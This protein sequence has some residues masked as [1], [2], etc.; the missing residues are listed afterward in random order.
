MRQWRPVMLL[1]RWQLSVGV[2]F[3]CIMN[4]AHLVICCSKSL[5]FNGSV[6]TF[7]NCLDLPSQGASIGWTLADD[8]SSTQGYYEL[9]LAFLGTAPSESGWVG[10]G[11]NPSK[12]QMAGSSVWV[13]Y[14]AANG[15]TLLPY[16][17]TGATLGGAPLQCSPVD[18]VVKA[19]A[20]QIS[21]VA[22]SML[23]TLQLNASMPTTLYHV[24]N[25]GP[26][27][28]AFQ[29]S[30]HSMQANDLNTIAHID[31]SSGLQSVQ[32][33]SSSTQ[34][35][36]NR[37][38]VI[39]T[40]AWGILLPMGVMSA[41]YIKPFADPHWFYMHMWM[42]CGGY[43]LAVSG[44]A[45]G[46]QLLRNSHGLVYKK[47]KNIGMVLFALSSLQV[48]ALLL[49]PKKEHKI[50]KYWNFYHHSVGYALIA[51]GIVN[52]F[53]GLNILGAP[54]WTRHALICSLVAL[55][56][57][58]I[59][60]ECITWV[61]FVNGKRKECEMRARSANS[62]APHKETNKDTFGPTEHILRVV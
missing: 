14:N 42:Q 47:H 56:A 48:M 45:T 13:A 5:S 4:W 15:S 44:W 27:V 23:L 38:G 43:I 35:L 9:E 20:V 17:L 21:G 36:K 37:H 2:F 46:V 8:A 57:I 39:N 41:R 22:M 32:S 49:R 62:N 7:V 61:V 50:R 59:L 58:S 51:L 53:I 10:W 19:A 33:P 16:K 11:L 18:Y 60:F 1:S 54:A 31:M 55:A 34:S 6:H 29:P 40:I 3:M 52:V 30:P 12:P 25:R 24:W 28:A 26:S